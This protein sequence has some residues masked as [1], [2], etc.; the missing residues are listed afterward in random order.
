MFQNVYRERESLFNKQMYSRRHRQSQNIEN[1][2]KESDVPLPV[3]FEILCS[4]FV[5][6]VKMLKGT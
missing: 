3:Y 6:A 2:N 1:N 5:S 4:P